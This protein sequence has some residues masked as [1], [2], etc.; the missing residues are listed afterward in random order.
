MSLILALDGALACASA[1]VVRDGVVLAARREPG[2]RG[3]AALLPAMAAAVL[4][5]AD[6]E[7]TALDAVGV[8]VG[9]G[10]F[11]GLRAALSLAQGIALAAGIPAIGVTVGEALAA[12]LPAGTPAWSVVDTK[13]GR[14]VLERIDLHGLAGPPEPM[15]IEALPTPPPGTLLVGDAAA[16]VAG[17]STLPDA[18]AVA[19]VAARRLTGT[20][21]PR[22]ARPLYV[23]PP[24]VQDVAAPA[25]QDAAPPIVRAPAG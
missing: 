14:V 7:A 23:Q 22:A 18:V 16:L 21:P 10:G 20:L 12:A 17:E 15:A 3:Q 11:T 4:A 24:A 1:A 13:R 8:T 2:E 5:E 6:I 25:V 19:A 9:P